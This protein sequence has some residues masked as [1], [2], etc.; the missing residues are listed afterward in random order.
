MFLLQRSIDGRINLVEISKCIKIQYGSV[1]KIWIKMD[2]T[3][4]NLFSYMSS[5]YPLPKVDDAL[6]ELRYKKEIEE[7][8]KV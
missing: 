7:Y 6:E 3:F 1:I 4:A 2:C 8:L 5:H